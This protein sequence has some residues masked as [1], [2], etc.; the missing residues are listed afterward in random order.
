MRWAKRANP[1]LPEDDVRNP[2]DEQALSKATEFSRE[3][4]VKVA[5]GQRRLAAQGFRL[6]GMPGYGL[7]RMLISEDGSR[8]Q[9]LRRGER[10]CLASDRVVLVPG[11]KR[12]ECIRTIFDLA[13]NDSK[14]V[15]ANSSGAQS[16]KG[17]ICRQRIVETSCIYN[18]LK[19][20]KYIGSNIWAKSCRSF[21]TRTHRLPKDEWTPRRAQW[22]SGRPLVLSMCRSNCS[23]A[24]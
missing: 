9:V 22:S 13:A 23:E 3:L 8:R 24:N 21:N 7:R 11:P 14:I 19:N 15:S 5:A 4:A 20:E 18:T 1:E 17:K 10:K 2:L 6:G 12:V 16:Q